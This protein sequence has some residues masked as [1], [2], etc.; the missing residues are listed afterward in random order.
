M[1]LD[2]LMQMLQLPCSSPASTQWLEKQLQESKD[3][4]EFSRHLMSAKL[5]VQNHAVEKPITPLD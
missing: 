1:Y 2:A 5:A 4:V 3:A